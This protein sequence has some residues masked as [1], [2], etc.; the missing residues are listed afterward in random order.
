MALETHGLWL[1]LAC[2]WTPP[3]PVPLT[4]TERLLHEAT[5]LKAEDVG[6]PLN[7]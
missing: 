5:P 4:P 6:A 2:D 3:K 7:T 1:N